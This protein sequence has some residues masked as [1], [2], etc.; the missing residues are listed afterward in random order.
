METQPDANPGFVVDE[1]IC[2]RAHKKD[3]YWT[4]WDSDL[5]LILCPPLP[6][7]LSNSLAGSFAAKIPKLVC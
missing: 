5:E 4:R 6:T 7:A 1:D 3:S 2:K